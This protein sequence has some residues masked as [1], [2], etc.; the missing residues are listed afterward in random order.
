MFTQHFDYLYVEPSTYCNLRCPRCP[1]TEFPDSYK[2]THLDI[3]VLQ[4]TLKS[5]LWKSLKTVEY[6]GNYGDPLMHPKLKEMVS[7]TRSIH[8]EVVQ[9]IHTSGN[10][11]SSFWGELLEFLSEKDQ[12]L[13]SIDGLEDTNSVYRV[14]SK[15]QWIEGALKLCPQKVRTIWKYIVFSHNESQIFEAIKMAKDFGVHFFILTKSHLFKGHWADESG[16]DPM[17]PS[18]PWIATAPD[19]EA[20]IEAKCQSS[21][22]HYLAANGNYSPCCW[23]NRIEALQLPV[24]GNFKEIMEHPQLEQIKKE[25][26]GKSPEICAKKCRKTIKARSSHQQITLDLKWDLSALRDQVENFKQSR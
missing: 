24:S 26:P 11:D 23:S 10:R 7:M 8:P 21:S 25:W 19:S 17:A 1:R 16:F 14:G 2:L 15:W 12:V 5:E 3:D 18:D 22:M 4:R 9:L 6:G 20:T 13:L